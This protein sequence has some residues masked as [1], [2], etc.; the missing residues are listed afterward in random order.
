MYVVASV[1]LLMVFVLLVI[2]FLHTD[3]RIVGVPV[4]LFHQTERNYMTDMLTY[5]VNVAAPA[6]KDVIQRELVVSAN[7]EVVTTRVMAG[8]SVDLGAFTVPQNSN[9]TIT[10]TDTDDAGN[11]SE[12]AVVDFVAIDTLPPQMPGVINVTLVS[13]T[14]GDAPV[15]SSDNV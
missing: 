6:D 13:E 7:G 2:M 4:V 3:E 1:L 10:V 5:V 14:S 9:V 12:P 15:E 8:S 11:R